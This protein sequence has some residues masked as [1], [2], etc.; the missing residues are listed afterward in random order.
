MRFLEA[1]KANDAEQV[2]A[3]E[4]LPQMEAGRSA[5]ETGQWG[6]G[7]YGSAEESLLDH[8]SRHGT[9][10]GAKDAAQYLRKAEGFSQNLRGAQK[11]PVPGDT[12]GVT[13]YKKLG[14]YIDI[15]S[16]GNIISFGAQ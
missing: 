15:D 7:S 14:K 6:K 3:A 1:L 12:P 16:E 8:F 10:V 11:S 9:E 2:A 13:R 4:R 5:M